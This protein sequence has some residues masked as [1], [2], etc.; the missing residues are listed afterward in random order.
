VLTLREALGINDWPRPFAERAPFDRERVPYFAFSAKPGYDL[1][2]VLYGAFVGLTPES[3]GLLS[4]LFGLG[5]LLVL[6]QL[7]RQVFDDRVAFAAV[8]ILAVSAYHVFYSGSQTPAV[9]ATF[10][11]LLGVSLYLRA[12]NSSSLPGVAIAGVTLAY[13]YGCHYNLLL[14]VLVIFG[15]HALRLAIVPQAGGIRG[16]LVMG[17]SFL[18][19]IAF[20]ELFYRLLITFAYEHLSDGRG[21]YLAQLRYAMGFFKWAIPSGAERFPMLLLDSEG[22]L[23]L[24]FA[25]FGLALSM[26]SGLRDWSQ[27][28]LL[29]LPIAHSVSA[30]YAGF[31][32][33][34]LFPRMI[35][36]ILPFVALWGGVGLVR[37]AEALRDWFRGWCAMPV[38]LTAGI[39]LVVVVGLPRAWAAANLRAGYEESARYV[40]EHGG[41]QVTLGLPVD[42]Y[43]L[44]SFRG[45]YPLPTSVEALQALKSSTDVRLLVLDHRVNILEEWGHPLGPILREFE[46]THRP[47]AVIANPLAAALLIAAENAMSRGALA[48]TLGDPH[49][50]EIR[51][52]DLAEFLGDR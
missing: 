2:L 20:F 31:S 23:V 48:R 43:Y 46:Q 10:F 21:A 50:G 28:I 30:V 3:V 25:L 38:A 19:V 47:E 6:H 18:G 12:A 5:T 8:A 24:G 17:L 33:S 13:A 22:W 32:G 15:I 42:Q 34:P 51:I 37:L 27:G 41:Q 7:T 49:S 9:V 52:Y 29:A 45:T 35:V 39:A 44:G 4:L 40:L 16:F 36:T 26:R 14:Y 11:L 1:I